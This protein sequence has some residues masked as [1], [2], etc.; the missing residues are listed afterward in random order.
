MPRHLIIL[1]KNFQKTYV[2]I[3]CIYCTQNHISYIPTKLINVHVLYCIN[4]YLYIIIIYFVHTYSIQNCII[5]W[6]AINVSRSFYFGVGGGD[7][8]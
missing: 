2:I 5:K 3:I 1:I 4:K 7:K 6:Q 8:N